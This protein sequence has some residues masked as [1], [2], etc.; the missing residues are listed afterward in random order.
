MFPRVHL[1]HFVSNNSKLYQVLPGPRVLILG[2][3]TLKKRAVLLQLGQAGVLRRLPEFPQKIKSSVSSVHNGI[4][5]V[6][7]GK[8]IECYAFDPSVQDWRYL[9]QMDGERSGSAAVSVEEGMWITGGGPEA[10]GDFLVLNSTI[11]VHANG[12]WVSC[13]GATFEMQEPKDFFL[14]YVY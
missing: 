1:L 3:E 2:D 14:S 5:Y 12:R 8:F 11:I 9:T 10:D 6:C 4:T 13:H 7:G